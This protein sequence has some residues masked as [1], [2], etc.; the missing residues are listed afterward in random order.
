MCILYFFC[1]YV[2]KY[3]LWVYTIFILNDSSIKKSENPK[4][5]T[6]LGNANKG[7]Q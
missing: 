1:I 6:I 3:A 2:Y 5:Y 7:Y 4:C